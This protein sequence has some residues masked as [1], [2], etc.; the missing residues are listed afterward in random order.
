MD[1]RYNYEDRYQ[2]V[3]GEIQ[4]KRGEYEQN[5]E[6]I[7]KAEADWNNQDDDSHQWDAVA[8]VNQHEEG[9]DEAIIEMPDKDKDED[10]FY[11]IVMDLQKPRS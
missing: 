11:D 10:E 2:Q 9:C 5:A 1:A 7:D 8:P 6:E 3:N 4:T